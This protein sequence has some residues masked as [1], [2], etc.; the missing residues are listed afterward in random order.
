MKNM[1]KYIQDARQKN[2]SRHLNFVNSP[3]QNF[4]NQPALYADGTGAGSSAPIKA[5]QPYV[6]V[7]SSASGA[8][9]NNFDVLGAYEYI[10][11]AGFN[12][13][14][15]LVIGSITISSGMPGITYRSLL[16]QSQNN[17]F[18]VGMTYVQCTSPADQVNQVFSIITK[19][20]NGTI[21]TIPIVPAID[22]YQQQ[23][24][25]NVVNQEYRIDGFTKLQFSQILPL[26]VLTIR[27]YPADN[28][29]PARA[30]AGSAAGRSYGDPGVIR[31]K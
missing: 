17:P 20:A 26:A 12:A 4:V 21:V 2:A 3:K 29:N 16:Y 7:V 1:Q 25:I 30:L 9:V 28:I 14:G 24:N 23:T 27:F 18:T 10:N 22:P 6:V 31:G 19:D 13:A 5:S 11:D 15:S 8:A